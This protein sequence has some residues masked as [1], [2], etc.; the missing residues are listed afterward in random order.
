MV[1]NSHTVS[2]PKEIVDF[3][4]EQHKRINEQNRSISREMEDMVRLAFEDFG[5]LSLNFFDEGED[6]AE[7]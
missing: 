3:M 1:G 5:R 4:N 2:I 6:D 7:N